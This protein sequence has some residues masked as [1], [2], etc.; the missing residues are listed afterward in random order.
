MTRFTGATAVTDSHTNKMTK[1]GI[2]AVVGA[3]NV[4]KSTTLNRLL[5]EKVSITS[6]VPQTTRNLVRGILNEKR[7]QVVF[8]DTPGVHK[9]KTELN[10]LMNAMARKAVEGT[11]AVMFVMDQSRTPQDEDE[12]W[13]RKATRFELPLIFVLNKSDV[14][15]TF[16]DAYR[17]RWNS[18]VAEKG[19]GPAGKEAGSTG[20][21]PPHWIEISAK[22]GENVDALLDLIFDRLP[23]GPQLFPD[24]ILTDFPRNWTIGDVVREKFFQVLR[25][26]LPHSV[27]VEVQQV[28][29]S[30]N[31][32]WRV[33]ADV[34]VERHPQ[35]GIVMGQKGRLLK[36]VTREAERELGEM[37]GHRVKLHLWVKVE[38]RWQRNHWILK[39]LGY[40]D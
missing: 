8:L 18:I 22:S 38:P 32:G 26:E 21:T 40:K 17:E 14:E 24:D 33:E 16:A 31:G 3:A 13:M 1:S 29:D 15:K 9:A 20:C 2:V 6:H 10:R 11:D 25:N 12:G 37:Y 5:E 35:K 39:R 34:L 36:K 27:A 19:L 28:E 7:G 30:D 4:G 23:Q